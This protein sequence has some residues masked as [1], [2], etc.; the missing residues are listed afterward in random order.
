MVALRSLDYRQQYGSF[1]YTVN[2]DHN[3][4]RFTTSKDKMLFHLVTYESHATGKPPEK[5]F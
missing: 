2:L 1:F 5:D 3:Y 4:V